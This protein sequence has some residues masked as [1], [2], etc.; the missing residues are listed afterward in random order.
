MEQ[1]TNYKREN[2]KTFKTDSPPALPENNGRSGRRFSKQGEQPA[3]RTNK[4]TETEE[5]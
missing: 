4:L 1:V 2:G 3:G 5:S